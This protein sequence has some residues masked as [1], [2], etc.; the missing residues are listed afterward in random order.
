MTKEKLTNEAELIQEAIEYIVSDLLYG[1]IQCMD[2]YVACRIRHGTPGENITRMKN[3][4][5]KEMRKY[6][7]GVY[8]V[9]VDEI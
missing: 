1:L 3:Y 7:K 9:E 4:V 5:E 8:Q 6:A 2:E